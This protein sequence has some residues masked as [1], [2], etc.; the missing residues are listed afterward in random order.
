MSRAEPPE[1]ER[2]IAD[3]FCTR[4]AGRVRGRLAQIADNDDE[5]IL[6]IA[7]IASRRGEYG[8]ALF[9]D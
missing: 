9:E 2:Y 7:R 4:A 6:A 1:Q 8:Y 3:T 5:R